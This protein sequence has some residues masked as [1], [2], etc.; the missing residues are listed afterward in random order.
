MPVRFR[1]LPAAPEVR[2]AWAAAGSSGVAGGPTEEREF[3]IASD[4]DE[5]RI[6]RQP[7]VEVELPFPAVSTLH[8]R[9]F[10]GELPADW[11]VEDLGSLNGTWVDGRRL[12]P[13]RAVPLRAG[14]RLRIASVDM[15]FEGWTATPRQPSDGA[16]AAES[17]ATIARRLISDLFGVVGGDLPRLVVES[18]SARQTYLVLTVR[19]RRYLTGRADSCDLVLGGE[20]VSREHAAF[21]RRADGIILQD[22]GSRNGLRVNGQPVSGERR[23]ADGDAITMGTA[24]LRLTDPEDRYLR[25]LE[26]LGPAPAE[27]APVLGASGPVAGPVSPVAPVFEV[28][29]ASGRAG[30]ETNPSS[31]RGQA[32]SP[33]APRALAPRSPLLS[34]HDPEAPDAPNSPATSP[35]T[36]SISRQFRP[37]GRLATFLIAT[38]AVFA[39]GALFALWLTTR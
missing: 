2:A 12:V 20:H 29:A 28:A 38:L 7:D 24:S 39:A 1:I 31:P 15:L 19:D 21:V 23:L 32:Q 17:T 25:R 26:R 6:G 10:R 33:A 30:V 11:R 16:P 37:W 27:G 18:G 35:G 9:I 4:L 8:A 36:T 5:L 3:E 13:R 14:Q 22:L 34:P